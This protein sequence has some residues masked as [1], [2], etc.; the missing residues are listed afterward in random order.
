MRLFLLNLQITCT[1]WFLVLSPSRFFIV[2]KLKLTLADLHRK[3][4]VNRIGRSSQSR[5]WEGKY[6][7][8]SSIQ[9]H[10]ETS[11]TIFQNLWWEKGLW[12]HLCSPSQSWTLRTTTAVSAA[13]GFWETLALCESSLTHFLAFLHHN[14]NINSWA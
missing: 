14:S 10:S 8:T 6:G 5:K 7:R 1:S 9:A 4:M 11:K 3:K 2:K 13:L 12:H